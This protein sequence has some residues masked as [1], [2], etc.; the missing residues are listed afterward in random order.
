MSKVSEWNKDQ[1]GKKNAFD[2]Y[3]GNKEN[4]ERLKIIEKT[5]LNFY[6]INKAKKLKI[7]D[8]GCGDGKICMMFKEMGF[9]VYGVDISKKNIKRINELGVQGEISNLEDRLPFKNNFFDYVFAGEIIEHVV[10]TKFF[11]EEV[12]RV[13]KKKGRFLV[14][15]PNLAHLPERFRLLMGKNPTQVSPIHKFLYLHVRQFTWDM[16]RYALETTGFK[17]V[18]MESTLVVFRWDGDKV[19]W[20]SKWLSWLIPTW[21]FTLIAEAQKK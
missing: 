16:L 3:F 14:T 6:K 4:S 12:N 15:T 20:S 10:D 18:G 17:V 5:V 1:F 11:L 8:L 2:Y 7:L 21:G 9:K 13:I 19:I